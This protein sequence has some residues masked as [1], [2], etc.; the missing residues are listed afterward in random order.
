MGISESTQIRKEMIDSVME[1]NN[2]V[3]VL[4]VAPLGG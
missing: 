3:K 2:P 1:S 4:V